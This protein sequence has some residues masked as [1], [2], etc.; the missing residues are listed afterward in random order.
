MEV[1]HR[2]FLT[3]K[4]YQEYQEG[5]NLLIGRKYSSAREKFE[6]A[7]VEEPDNG[8]ILLRAGQSAL[9]DNNTKEALKYLRTTRKLNPYCL[10]T[11]L[12]LGRALHLS[13]APQLAL[14][15]FQDV[16]KGMPKSEWAT[17]WLAET[18]SSLG[19]T[20]YALILLENDIKQRP[21]H[22]TSLITN[23][24]LRFQIKSQSSDNLWTARKNL[25]LAL[26]RLEAYY[27]LDPMETEGA[28]WI[29]QRKP[30]ADLRSELH[31]LLQATQLKLNE[32]VNP[33]S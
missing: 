23:A 5:V 24:K 11:R 31:R 25:Q 14:G 28:L 21:L 7:L 22:V 6:K 33:K 4:T 8:E 10:D 1:I 2:L 17:V 26:S 15:E 9:L 16:H 19:Q 18:L 3:N 29:D 20:N 13:G 27:K 32:T 12:W 30:V